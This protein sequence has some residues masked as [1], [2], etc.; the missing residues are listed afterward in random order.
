MQPPRTFSN[1]ILFI[2][3]SVWLTACIGGG[4]GVGTAT[5]T[6]SIGQTGPAGGIVF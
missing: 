4:S 1:I 5:N 3:L 6:Y 2:S